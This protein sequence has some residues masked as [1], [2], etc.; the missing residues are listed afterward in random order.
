MKKLILILLGVALIGVVALTYRKPKLVYPVRDAIVITN[1]YI[2]WDQYCWS[3][4]A[5]GS[6]KKQFMGRYTYYATVT[7]DDRISISTCRQGVAQ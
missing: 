6:I 5:D 3:E 4:Y 2:Q 7:N 1:Q